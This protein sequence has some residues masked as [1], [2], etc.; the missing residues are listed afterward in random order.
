MKLIYQF[1]IG[2]GEFQR[3]KSSFPFYL[4]QS[5]SS[6]IR[7]SSQV[8]FISHCSKPQP[9]SVFSFLTLLPPSFTFRYLYDFTGPIQIIKYNLPISGSLTS[10]VKHLLPCKV[11]DS[12]VPGLGWRYL[13]DGESGTIILPSA[14][15]AANS[16]QSCPTLCDPI[17]GSPPGS[18]VTGTLHARSY[19]CVPG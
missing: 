8:F 15:A 6:I 12:Q 18:T 9:P 16:L 19:K 1:S 7:T 11:T 17:D 13:R 14:A 3:F 2:L 5:P 10:S 4:R